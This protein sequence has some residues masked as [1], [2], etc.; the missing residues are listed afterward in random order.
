M[1]NNNDLNVDPELKQTQVAQEN[2]LQSDTLYWDGVRLHPFS[3]RRQAAADLLGL[4]FGHL[5]DEDAH[6]WQSGR[7]YPGFLRDVVLILFLCISNNEA[8]AQVFDNTQRKKFL[9][10]MDDWAET[11]GISL[12]SDPFMEAAKLFFQILIPVFTARF[13]TEPGN[14]GSIPKN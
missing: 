6:E 13:Y 10:R 4:K 5:R 7:H 12:G 1:E 14:K 9:E 3:Y 8:V 2:F 11:H